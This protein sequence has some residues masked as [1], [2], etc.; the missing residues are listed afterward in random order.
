VRKCLSAGMFDVLSKPLNLK[1]FKE[2]LSIM[3]IIYFFSF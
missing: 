2:L 3:W 1:E